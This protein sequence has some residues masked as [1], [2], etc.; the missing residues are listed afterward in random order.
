MRVGRGPPEV[1]GST[2]QGNVWVPVQ[3]LFLP[4][5]L[6][7]SPVNRTGAGISS[8]G[9]RVWGS[10]SPLVKGG[11]ICAYS[12]PCPFPGTPETYVTL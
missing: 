1:K 4:P 8:Q 10:G 3:R 12:L 7:L 11:P 6:E 5:A 9:D 2:Q